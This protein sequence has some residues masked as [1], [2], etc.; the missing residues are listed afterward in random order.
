MARDHHANI[1]VEDAI[2]RISVYIVKELEKVSIGVFGVRIL[3]LDKL[4]ETG[5]DFV[6]NSSSVIE[7]GANNG[8][9]AEDAFVV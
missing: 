9:D 3:L 8:L 1:S 2:F 7:E 4:V 6:I 5:K